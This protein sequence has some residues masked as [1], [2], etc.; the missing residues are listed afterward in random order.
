[1]NIFEENG[2]KQ[3]G[4]EN[5]WIKW[6]KENNSVISKYFATIKYTETDE[7]N[8]VIIKDHRENILLN[9]NDPIEIENFFKIIRRDN[10]INDILNPEM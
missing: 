5:I 3:F 2:F 4:H 1:M 9:S 10:K 7:N 6:E 8:Y